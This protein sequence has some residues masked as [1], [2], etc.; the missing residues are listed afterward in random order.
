MREQWCRGWWEQKGYG[1]QEMD[2]LSISITGDLISGS[3]RDVAG[4]FKL[5]GFISRQGRVW[6]LK[7]YFYVHVAVYTGGYD[8][9]GKLSGRWWLWGQK[10]D[11]EITLGVDLFGEPLVDTAGAP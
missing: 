5:A 11:W 6:M 10:G 1:R 9:S 4:R 7:R 8:G 2:P 3:G